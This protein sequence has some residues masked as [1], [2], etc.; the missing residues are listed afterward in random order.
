LDAAG[1]INVLYVMEKVSSDA[2]VT[3]ALNTRGKIDRPKEAAHE[4]QKSG[5]VENEH[6]VRLR[7]RLQPEDLLHDRLKKLREGGEKKK[8]VPVAVQME[9]RPP[10][11]GTSMPILPAKQNDMHIIHGNTNLTMNIIPPTTY[12]PMHIQPVQEHV[13]QE[14]LLSV[15]P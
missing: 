9:I 14:M 6:S 12:P 3:A 11:P 1:K 15:T 10:A 8:D 13:K 2:P 7:D 4:Q 5:R